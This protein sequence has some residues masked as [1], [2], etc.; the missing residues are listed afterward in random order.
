MLR[1]FEH[2]MFEEMSEPGPPRLFV[3]GPDVVP[4]VDRHNRAGVILVQKHV[5]AVLERLFDKRNVHGTGVK[6]IVGLV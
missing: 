2:Q 1:T 6:G 5:E 4:D 3:L